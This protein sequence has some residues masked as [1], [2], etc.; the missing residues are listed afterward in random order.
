VRNFFTGAFK[1]PLFTPLVVY[2]LFF[3]P[4][5]GSV[6]SLLAPIPTPA[7]P[8]SAFEEIFQ[9]FA[10]YIPASAL[11]LYFCFQDTPDP[12]FKQRFCAK[13]AGIFASAVSPALITLASTAAL[14]VIGGFTVFFENFFTGPDPLHPSPPESAVS[15]VIFAIIVSCVAA[16]YLEESFF[17]ILLYRRLLASGLK[18][19]YAVLVSS[20]LFAVCHA[21]EGLWGMTGA[22]L[23]G[24]FLSFLFERKGSL[25]IISL[26]HAM[27]N[28]TVYLLHL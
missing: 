1:N 21:W 4:D 11:V 24:V 25:N 18:K 8:Y 3:F 5:S 7:M 19:V 10:F 14:L 22:F 28:I 2:I 27:Y 20:L 6:G 15:A 23:S 16:A 12:A 17:R 26:S 9:V 13:R